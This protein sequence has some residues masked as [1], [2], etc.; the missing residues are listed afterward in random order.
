MMG[1]CCRCWVEIEIVVQVVVVAE[2]TI[3]EMAWKVEGRVAAQ[4]ATSSESDSRRRSSTGARSCWPTSLKHPTYRSPQPFS[5]RADISASQGIINYYVSGIILKK[6]N[7][8]CTLIDV[9]YW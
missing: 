5:G 1:Y 7:Q 2:T 8:K 9:Q 4:F 3:A 6:H